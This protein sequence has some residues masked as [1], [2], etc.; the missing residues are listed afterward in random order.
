ML[1]IFLSFLVLFIPFVLL[2]FIF[3]S[4]QIV[5]Y[6]IITTELIICFILFSNNFYKKHILWKEN[7]YSFVHKLPFK[8]IIDI[9]LNHNSLEL[10]TL[11]DSSFSTI[12]TRNYT[13][14]CKEH[15]F[16]KSQICPITHIIIEN[17]NSNNYDNYTEI[18]ISYNKYLYFTQNYSYE[19]LYENSYGLTTNLNFTSYYFNFTKFYNNSISN[20]TTIYNAFKNFKKYAKFFDFLCL[21]LLIFSLIYSFIESFDDL[22]FT[23]FKIINTCIQIAIL[24]IYIFRYIKFKEIKNIIENNL[25]ENINEENNYE[26]NKYFNID[27][28]GVAGPLNLLIINLLFVIIPKKFHILKEENCDLDF[29][30]YNFCYQN[31]NK[32]LHILY[33]FLP[34]LITSIIFIILDFIN[35]LKIIKNYN[36]MIYNWNTN[37]IKSI[38]L[39]SKEDYIFAKAYEY[40]YT[41]GPKNYNG[42][43][44]RVKKE[45]K[46]YDFNNWKGNYFKIE[47][48]NNFDYTNIYQK[49]NGNYVEKIVMEI[50]YFFQKI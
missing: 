16:I 25:Y 48:I 21:T 17:D 46:E 22:K 33:L 32:D 6:I 9:N 29:K 37:P 41:D 8:P 42:E 49:E 26:P 36:N 28:F 24:I 45:K 31:E 40:N 30:E 43:P 4:F 34:F 7:E 27:S 11:D 39:S 14:K 12:M 1:E 3:P 50:I 38:E 10:K 20:D 19:G 2:S 23:Y 15:F 13:K 44:I 47:R 35:D 18:K 5:K